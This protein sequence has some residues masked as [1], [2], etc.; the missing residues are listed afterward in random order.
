MLDQGVELE[1]MLAPHGSMTSRPPES[2][3]RDDLSA[4]RLILEDRE[5]VDAAQCIVMKDRAM[6]AIETIEGTDDAIRRAGR[7]GG[8][9]ATVIKARRKGQDGRFDLPAVGPD[10]IRT[11]VAAGARALAIEAGACLVLDR[12]ATIA[13][14][15]EAGIAIWGFDARQSAL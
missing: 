3:A 4:G 5:G 12:A 15:E 11:M 6:L 1:A 8:A 9:G 10:T 2:S 14:A 13:A 7:S